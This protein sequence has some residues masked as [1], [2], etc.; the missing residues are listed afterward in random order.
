MTLIYVFAIGFTVGWML[1]QR[2]ECITSLMNRATVWLHAKS[3]L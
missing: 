3:G 1:V 2:P